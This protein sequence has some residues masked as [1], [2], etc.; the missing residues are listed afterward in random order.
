MPP[1]NRERQGTV[2]ER[3]SRHRRGPDSLGFPALV[4]PLNR[5]ES[6]VQY[7]GLQALDIGLFGC[8]MPGVG[9]DGSVRWQAASASNAAASKRDTK[10]LDLGR[11][12]SVLRAGTQVPGLL[13]LQGAP[14]PAEMVR[15]FE[16]AH[17]ELD[18]PRE[19]LEELFR[20]PIDS[21]QVA[22]QGSAIAVCRSAKGDFKHGADNESREWILFAGSET[23]SELWMQP[24]RSDM[25]SGAFCSMEFTTAIR[26]IRTHRAHL[27][28]ACVRTDSMAALVQMVSDDPQVTLQIS[29]TP[30]DYGSRGADHWVCDAA[31]SPWMASE[32]ALASATGDVRLW[33]C[34]AARETSAFAGR[35]PRRRWAACDYWG[36]PRV[37][38]CADNTTLSCVDARAN[39]MNTVFLDTTQS[40]FASAGEVITAAKASETHPLHAIAATTHYIRIYDRRYARQPLLAW[41]VPDPDDPPVRIESTDIGGRDIV[42]S[43]TKSA[44]V[45][46]FEYLQPMTDAPFVSGMQTVLDPPPTSLLAMQDAL[47]IDPT[48]ETMPV[49]TRLE[50]LALYTGTQGDTACLTLDV[51][52][53]IA[54]VQLGPSADGILELGYSED[55][56]DV[57][58]S[59]REYAWSLVRQCGLPFERAD[60]RSVYRYLVEGPQTSSGDSAIRSFMA[61]RKRAKPDA[62]KWHPSLA[63]VAGSLSAD[64]S[65]YTAALLAAT[66]MA[67]KEQT[68]RI[69]LPSWSS[70]GK[71]IYREAL[72]QDASAA[73]DMAE[74]EDLLHKKAASST[75]NLAM[76]TEDLPLDPEQDLYRSIRAALKQVFGRCSNSSSNNSNSESNS[77]SSS[78]S[79]AVLVDRALDRAAA[80]IA[81]SKMLI[82]SGSERTAEDLR[83]KLGEMPEHAQLLDRIWSGA[84]VPGWSRSEQSLTQPSGS[85]RKRKPK[86]LS[87]ESRPSFTQPPALTRAPEPESQAGRRAEYFSQPAPGVASAAPPIHVPSLVSASSSRAV[88][89]SVR[90][91]SGTTAK[92]SQGKK[93]TKPRKSGF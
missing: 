57:H 52:G 11:K 92:M 74:F 67:T 49:R 73:K 90:P 15:Q 64:A 70:A 84:S 56:V 54:A 21:A 28:L 80:D 91:S 78:N 39:R 29:G 40:A 66:K 63:K 46:V 20:D 69:E 4:W 35:G 23:K 16:R 82:G 72:A 2:T 9:A 25:Q 50:G 5:N 33:D 89:P 8:M 93:K 75:G 43:A 22:T 1:Q 71:D 32:I 86:P 79:K 53:G 81:L 30:Y 47:A 27:G 26:Q 17:V 88:H 3:G 10:Q 14:M 45:S 60:L 77:E 87:S 42:F 37:L 48:I 62:L 83:E 76:E 13:D 85:S 38:L 7:S 61:E 36:A 41:E 58:R 59:R 65:A 6:S 34:S 51:L 31:W 44:Q 18:L 12:A 55:S 19:L 68:L 24:L